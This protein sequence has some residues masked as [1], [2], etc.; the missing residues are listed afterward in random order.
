MIKNKL[1]Q[2]LYLRCLVYFFSLAWLLPNHYPPWGAFH[3]DAY[4]A[5]ILLLVATIVFFITA[6]RQ[7]VWHWH[8][9]AILACAFIPLGQYLAGQIT[10]FGTAWINMAYLVGLACA[11]ALGTQWEKHAPGRCGDFLFSALLPAGLL[12]VAISLCQWL[13]LNVSDLWVLKSDRRPFGNLSQAN[14]TATLYVLSTIGCVWLYRRKKISGLLAGFLT[15]LLLIGLAMSGSRTGWVNAVLIGVVLV[16]WSYKSSHKRWAAAA[17]A[18]LAV[19][20]LFISILPWLGSL[21]ALSE[22][23]DWGGRS[24]LNGRDVIWQLVWDAATR[25]PILGY[26]WGQTLAATL[27]VAADHPPL[28]SVTTYSHNL[29]LDLLLWNGLILGGIFCFA[30]ASWMLWIASRVKTLGQWLLLLSLSVLGFHAMTE[31]PLYYAYFLLPAGMIVGMLGQQVGAA[32]VVTTSLKPL[33]ALFALAGVFLTVTIR[34]YL[35]IETGFT[36]V[37]FESANMKHNLPTTPPDVWA[38]TDLRGAIVMARWQPEKGSSAAE[39]ETMKSIALAYASG[40]N[41]LKM[42]KAYGLNGDEKSAIYWLEIGCHATPKWVC[43]KMQVLW[44]ND[45]RL[46]V[47]PWPIK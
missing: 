24:L 16:G 39:L 46:A 7:A 12:S 28:V 3:N 11:I 17:V 8:T 15:A 19:L 10:W 37:R 36:A 40:N 5:F 32:V 14:Q 35:H 29:F 41:I 27:N 6:P 20:G 18:G 31:F 1:H 43:P 26:G 22:P 42:A 44:E 45:A 2:S 13:D 23:V 30:I 25:Q 33:I 38:L 4:A 34:D 47:M 9:V 21:L